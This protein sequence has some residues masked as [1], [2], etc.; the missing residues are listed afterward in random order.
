MLDFKNICRNDIVLGNIMK[1]EKPERHV[2]DIIFYTTFGRYCF[3]HVEPGTYSLA[4][5]QA[6]LLRFDDHRFIQLRHFNPYIGP[7]LLHTIVPKNNPNNGVLLFD[8]PSFVGVGY[9]FVDQETIHPCAWLPND[10]YN[11]KK[12]IKEVKHTTNK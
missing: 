10:S 7:L 4:E 11:L 6:M 9:H 1:V 2:P 8:S 12:L 3:G 5:E